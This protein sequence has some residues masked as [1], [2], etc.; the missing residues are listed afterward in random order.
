MIGKKTIDALAGICD[1]NRFQ[2][3]LLFVPSYSIGHQIG[4]CLAKGGTPWINLR[5]TTPVG[6]A[7]GLLA[8]DLNMAGIHLI[9]SR[10][11]LLV[12][13]KLYLDYGSSQGA[14]HYFEGAAEIPGILRCLSNAVHEIRM[15]GLEKSGIDPGAFITPEKGEELIWLLESYESFLAGNQ[16][17]DHAGLLK[18]ATEKLEKGESAGKDRLVLV[19]TDFPLASLEKRLIRLASGEHLVTIPH[20]TPLNMDVPKRFFHPSQPGEY[21]VADLKKDID[22][23]PLLFVPQQAPDPVGEG[24]VSIFHALGEP[25]EVREI[26]RRLFE[27]ETPLDDVELVV[28]RT[29]PYISLIY[30][31][32]GSLELP[33]T[34]AGG[35]PITYTRPGRALIIYFKWQAEDFKA[36]YAG[37][38][39][40]G[41]YLDLDNLKLEGQKPSATRAAAIIRDAAIG[42]G[43]ERYRSRLGSLSERYRCRAEE[44]RVEGEVEKAN[45][46]DQ[47]AA[48]VTWVGRFIEEI[49]KTV[50]EPGPD[51]TVTTRELCAGALDFMQRFCRTVGALDVAAKLRLVDLLETIARAP[52]LSE[53]AKDSAERLGVL[54]KEIS[55]GSSTPKPGHIHVAHYRSGGYSGR[56]HTYV[57][58]L[59]QNRFPGASLQDPVI[60]D[61]E[62][63]K[64]GPDLVLA[65]DILHENSYVMAKL[66]GS[67]SGNV[68][69]S[70]SCRD[71]REDREIF[72]SSILLRIYRLIT[73]DRSGDYQALTRFLGEPAGFIP[74]EKATPLN[75]WEWWLSQKGAVYGSESV[76]TSYPNLK[77]GD[78]AE[79]E[80][81]LDTLCQ[82]DGWVRAA[83]GAMD[84]ISGE[85]TLSCSRLEQLAKC[86]FGFFIRHVL[87]IEPLDEMEIEPG[88][89]LDPLQR[90]E[91]LHHVFYRFMEEIKTRGEKPEFG[92]HLGFFE[93]IAMEEVARW[94]EEV[95][96]SSDLAFNREVADIKQA[97][98]IFLKDE[99]ERC[100]NVDPLFF[101]LAF[102]IKGDRTSGVSSEEPVTIKLKGGGS[103]KLRGRIDRVDRC[104]AHQY[105]VWDYKTGSTWGYKEEGYLNK[106]R[107]LQHALYAV[108]T[109]ILL[110][111]KLDKK[112]KVVRAGY[113]F[114]SPKGEGLRIEK[115]P[116]N[117]DELYE[118]LDELFELLQSGIFASAYDKEP[119]GI[120][121]YDSIC[122]GPDVAVERC[123]RKLLVDGK[124]APL[125]RLKGYA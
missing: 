73:A 55:V 101:E 61:T 4:E 53:P 70:Y 92:K 19:L 102:G 59:D 26:F 64:L 21:R 77:E 60:L 79:E 56:S 98:Q 51:D 15:A 119:C 52:S 31:I 76:H 114:P 43:R 30:E 17:T 35:I 82:Y 113:F 81:E 83:A 72:P 41:G 124:L 25:N 47:A 32:A 63:E 117:R 38:L 8:L 120:C 85:T 105:E 40:S 18:M 74:S 69:L 103:F 11:R 9:D 46:S 65:S 123:K 97:L 116:L 45:W 28:T 2:E 86:P 106:G 94:K 42:W 91:L 23:L 57:L 108:A 33:T 44:W 99:E 111:R 62:R 100:K 93:A 1:E 6:Y 13:E 96:P 80:R 5:V 16:L 68:T 27:D 49:M 34:F 54:A 14:A 66:L 90:G 88:R 110:R 95:P 112:A 50:P 48:K 20:T 22:L 121:P 104:K 109:E 39:L 118:V 107:H 3:K 84:S 37:R 24:S 78:R 71:V 29:D 7:Q 122:G 58:G 10:E 87:G 75:G 36:G 12:I 67:L 89:W 125:E 115:S